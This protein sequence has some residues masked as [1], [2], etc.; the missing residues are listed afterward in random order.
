MA[1]PWQPATIPAEAARLPPV[2][3]I[4]IILG[5]AG[6]IGSHVAA[7]LVR[8]GRTV[9][10]A[11]K[12]PCAF[13][14]EAVI[15]ERFVY[16]DLRRDS[17]CAGV[18]TMAAQLAQREEKTRP[19]WAFLFAADMGGMGYIAANESTILLSNTAITV[20]V[21]KACVDSRVDRLFVASSAC[22]YPVELQS[23]S[24]PPALLRED[25]AWPAHPQDGYG[26]EKLY[27]EEIAMRAAA[28]SGSHLQVRVAR[29]HNVYGPRGTWIGGREKAPGAFLR[30][31]LFL[32][33]MDTILPDSRHGLEVWGDGS[34]TR[35]F[36]FIDDAVRG[37]LALMCS[38][39]ATPV[40]IGSDEAVTIKALA[41][42]AGE[43]VGADRRALEPRLRFQPAGPIGVQGRSA[44]LTKAACDLDWAPRVPLAAG[45][46]ATAEW[47][48]GEVRTFRTTTTNAEEWRSFLA[49]GLTSPHLKQADTFRFG[50]LVPVT[51]RHRGRGVAAGIRKFVASLRETTSVDSPRAWQFDI[52]FGVD[53]GDAVCDPS[54]KGSLDL[55]DIVRSEL[56]LACALGHVTARVRVL[57]YPP[58]N[59]CRI[60]SDLAAE[61]F[62]SG[63]DFV[64]LLGDDIVL[65]SPGWADAVHDAFR[66]IAEDKRLPFGFGCVAMADTAFPGFPT[67]P[68]LHRTHADVFSGRI[69]PTTFKNQDADPFLFQLYRA[70]DA[71]R[72][73]PRARLNNTIGGA[74][75]ARYAK[76]HVPWTGGT[77]SSAREAAAHWLDLHH[78]PARHVPIVTLDVIVPTFRAPLAMLEAILALRVP[79]GVSTQI[80]I[81]C[82]RPGH[83]GS[84]AV[85]EM[86]QAKHRDNPMVRIR[87]N[88]VN[89]G[90]GLT[91]NRGFAE[92][93]AD[94]VLFL[95]DD[96]VP[97]AGI[98][99]AYA[100]AIRAH[101]RATGF[102]G[103]SVLPPPSN[104][105]QAGVHIAGVAFFWG[106]AKVNPT[107]TELP[108]GVTANLCVRRPPPGTL[109]FNGAFPKTG[110]GEDIDFCLRLREYVRSTVRDSE[111]FVAT[112]AAVITHPWWDG[113]SPQYSH[114]SGW[115]WGD[116]HLIDLFPALTYR[117]LPDLSET[118]L[119]VGW[120]GVLQLVSR[121]ALNRGLLARLP[122]SV[123]GPWCK[124][125]STKALLATL[126]VGG[127]C[128]LGD[129]VVDS[130]NEL[131]ERPSPACSHLPLST[132][133]AG[134]LHG[135]IIRT[136]S[137]SGRLAGHASRGTLLT[138]IGRRFNWFG[139]MWDGAPGV[140]RREALRRNLVRASAAFTAVSL[141]MRSY[142]R[143]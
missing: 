32:R 118:L 64:V 77:L 105:R 38:S 125:S 92:S 127:A 109:E 16:A 70:F 83:A 103:H 115:A 111:G 87:T 35:T 62:S 79:A 53:A 136:V 39:V 55:L 78:G 47:L 140:E 11:E 23:A 40:N 68:V 135:L 22:V 17:E 58:G 29:F 2:D 110:G 130:W 74:G 141:L 72:M 67:F 57:H 142:G 94:W 90:A 15:C 33:E 131:V 98:I 41:L 122:P 21:V 49:S 121:A 54:E 50:L 25:A 51:S 59:I 46:K 107:H 42:L 76:R 36:C 128:I 138:N 102:I 5:G 81:I 108:W 88:A 139:Y 9:I 69:F 6:F 95:D 86:L 3:A 31:A 45:L 13:L 91:R 93:A 73:E 101:P 34:Q 112:P 27:G 30:K 129:V 106:V 37:V 66:C 137:E 43:A 82:D 99:E 120:L 75:D 1:Q 143:R 134:V 133:I 10:V 132:R 52:I 119:A 48:E 65:E 28:S 12:Q 114:F 116:G 14:S 71:A 89:L 18:F 7:E 117:N 97:D 24:G 20:N 8:Q 126:A 113:G 26:L 104:A 100:D 56:P 124:F 4:C 96:V 19:V 44:D 85:M 63:D 84:G 61:A 60:W 80:T 123:S